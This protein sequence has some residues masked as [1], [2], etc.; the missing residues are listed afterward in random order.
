VPEIGD[1][2]RT[3]KKQPFAASLM[4][5]P[6]PGTGKHDEPASSDVAVRLIV[7]AEFG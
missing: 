6:R 2:V 5:V 7:V 1:S 4:F 3:I